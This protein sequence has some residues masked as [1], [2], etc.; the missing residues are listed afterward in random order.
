MFYPKTS[1][2]PRRRWIVV[3]R[4]LS[5]QIGQEER[6]GP[7][8]FRISGEPVSSPDQPTYIAFV[9]CDTRQPV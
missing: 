5:G 8:L 3:W 1:E 2:L 9:T 6:S 7:Q 4:P